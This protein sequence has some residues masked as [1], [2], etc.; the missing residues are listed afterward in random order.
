MAGY[1]AIPLIRKL[2]IKRDARVLLVNAPSGYIKMAGQW[3]AGAR[4]VNENE[5]NANFIHLFVI[6]M[7]ELEYHLPTMKKQL[8]PDGM[9]WVS[10]YKKASK[11]P[12]DVSE[13]LIRKAAI[14]LG[15]VDI[16]VCAIDD[17]WSGL[18]LVIRKSNR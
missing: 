5:S 3:P 17:N 18:K 6:S 7:E 16:K 9:L 2:G 8:K 12:T 10:W 1:S 11:I 13:D 4:L 14:A 15:L